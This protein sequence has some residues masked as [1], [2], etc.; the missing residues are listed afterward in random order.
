MNKIVLFAA[1][2]SLS[3]AED[4]MLKRSL[5]E[6]KGKG[7]GKGK[8]RNIGHAPSSEMKPLPFNIYHTFK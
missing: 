1:F 3:Q 8:G 2:A 4:W 5:G 6:A 7:K